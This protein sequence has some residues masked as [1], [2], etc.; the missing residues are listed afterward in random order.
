MKR[1]YDQLTAPLWRYVANDDPLVA[2]SNFLAV[3][4]A[5]NTPLYPVYAG[6]VAGWA[7]MPWLLL[8]W[9]SFPFF[10][11]VPAVSRRSPM[12]GRVM[13]PVV[14]TI[15]TLFCTWLLGVAAG[16][17]LFLLSC[18]MIAALSFR[19]RERLVMLATAIFPMLAYWLLADRFP[20]PPHLYEA[21]EAAGLLSMNA[22]S[23]GILTIFSAIIFARA[24]SEPGPALQS[25]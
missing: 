12:A 24:L 5:W 4:I 6:W 14:G 17:Q 22:A 15:N 1:F 8:T 9:L 11:A 10:A 3:V 20:P 19:P 25:R 7:G 2:A 18:I 16:E 21:S 13:F 23:V